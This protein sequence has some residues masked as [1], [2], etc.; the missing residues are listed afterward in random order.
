[1]ETQTQ[2]GRRAAVVNVMLSGRPE[3]SC[4]VSVHGYS[5]IERG[6]WMTDAV[7]KALSLTDRYH[8]KGK[9]ERKLRRADPD[10][11]GS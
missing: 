6:S 2:A 5:D 3:N 9:M 1:M 11:S 4:P 8:P 7:N 10:E